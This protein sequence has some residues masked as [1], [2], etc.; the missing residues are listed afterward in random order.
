MRHAK[1]SIISIPRAANAS[2]QPIPAGHRWHGRSFA[3]R[4]GDILIQAGRY[5]RVILVPLARGGAR[6]HFLQRGGAR[7]DALNGIMKLKQSGADADAY[8]VFSR[9]KRMRY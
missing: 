3:T 2:P 5:D 4:L 7:V 1:P 8:S 9:E 6:F